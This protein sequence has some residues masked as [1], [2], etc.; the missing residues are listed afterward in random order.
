MP[1]LVGAVLRDDVVAGQDAVAPQQVA[2]VVERGLDP[3]LGDSHVAHPSGSSRTGGLT[4][5]RQT[6]EA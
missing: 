3:V 4:I 5:D 1:G 2:Q 6:S